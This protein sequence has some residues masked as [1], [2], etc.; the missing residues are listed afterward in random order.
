MSSISPAPWLRFALVVWAMGLPGLDALAHLP[1]RQDSPGTAVPGAPALEVGPNASKAA[2]SSLGELAAQEIGS[3]LSAARSAVETPPASVAAALLGASR[4]AAFP[5]GNGGS[6]VGRN[7]SS[8]AVA[9]AEAAAEEALRANQALL[10]AS[11]PFEGRPSEASPV[12]QELLWAFQAGTSGD[13][14]RPP[15]SSLMAVGTRPNSA[16]PLGAASLISKA[17]ARGRSKCSSG[18]IVHQLVYSS[19][20][21]GTN[22]GAASVVCLSV[23][24]VWALW[25]CNVY[26]T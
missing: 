23:C 10:Q 11:P 8:S 25:R 14:R 1:T 22:V 9:L 12:H 20:E 5:T 2:P 21:A 26:I 18:I 19:T 3:F 7:G 15:P 24:I 16:V 13:G 6:E 17:A 4:V